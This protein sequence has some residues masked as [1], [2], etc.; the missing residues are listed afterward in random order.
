MSS[1]SQ[2]ATSHSLHYNGYVCV[3]ICMCVYIDVRMYVCVC[4][5]MN[6]CVCKYLKSDSQNSN[7]FCRTTHESLVQKLITMVCLQTKQSD[8]IFGW[9]D[10]SA[11][12]GSGT[13]TSRHYRTTTDHKY[14]RDNGDNYYT[15]V[16]STG[17]DSVKAMGL[18]SVRRTWL[19]LVRYVLVLSMPGIR[20]YRSGYRSFLRTLLH[21][22][23]VHIDVSVF[24]SGS[25]FV[26]LF[27]SWKGAPAISYTGQFVLWP[28]S[29]CAMLPVHS[30]PGGASSRHRTTCASQWGPGKERGLNS[31]RAESDQLAIWPG[32]RAIHWCRIDGNFRSPGPLV[33]T[34]SGL[35]TGRATDRVNIH[36]AGPGDPIDAQCTTVSDRSAI[37]HRLWNPCHGSRMHLSCIW[38]HIVIIAPHTIN[39]M[40][41]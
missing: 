8:A 24:P 14:R 33:R 20:Q 10:G 38:F 18:A 41:Q 32:H 36:S 2:T 26:G 40:W 35:R 39:Q 12:N 6:V 37:S 16:T 5:F 23:F 22:L 28:V 3:C 9:C 7:N 34:D 17:I 15:T 29:L 11:S 27:F 31:F 30:K 13:R 25:H 1:V 4:V 21:F 19:W